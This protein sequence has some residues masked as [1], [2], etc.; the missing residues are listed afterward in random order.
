MSDTK[1]TMPYGTGKTVG[2]AGVMA[3][4]EKEMKY[5]ECFVNAHCAYDCPNF[6]IDIANWKYCPKC[7]QALD[8][9]GEDE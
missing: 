1:I 5:R 9:G 2:C 8:W 4:L 6:Q 3:R 7:G